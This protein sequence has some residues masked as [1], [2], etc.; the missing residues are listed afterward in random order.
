VLVSSVSCRKFSCT[1][2]FRVSQISYGRILGYPWDV[3][4]LTKRKLGYTLLVRILAV[5]TAQRSTM[6]TGPYSVQSQYRL[7]LIRA[8]SGSYFVT[9]D[10]R[11]SSLNWPVWP[12]TRDP[13]LCLVCLIVYSFFYISSTLCDVH[14]LI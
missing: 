2:N 6:W 10:P 1:P 7:V 13:W 11:D 12:T 4:P 8:D 14:R 3:A 9:H 5:S